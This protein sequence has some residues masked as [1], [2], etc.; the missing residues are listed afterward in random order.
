MLLHNWILGTKASDIMVRKLATVRTDQ[1]VA[2]AAAIMLSE[3]ITGL[4]VI[5][6]AGVCRGVFS[7]TDVLRAEEKVSQQQREVT[8]NFFSSNLALPESVYLEKLEQVRDKLS[9]TAEQ[10]VE[11]FMTTDLVSVSSEDSLQEIVQSM[12]DAHLHRVL[13][14][15]QDKRLQGIIA[16]TDV[17]A[18]LLRDSG[19]REISGELRHL[20]EQH[21]S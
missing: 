19:L 18:A 21:H 7:V 16:T 2:E 11:H 17:L 12:V 6:L 14:I 20:Q 13:V 15:D 5:D 10:P 8:S 9:P 1:S 4:P 3:Q